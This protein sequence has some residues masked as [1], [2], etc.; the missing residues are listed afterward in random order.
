MYVTDFRNM[1]RVNKYL[2]LD[3]N[4][5]HIATI[6]FPT[7]TS[8]TPSYRVVPFFFIYYFNPNLN[9]LNTILF[10]CILFSSPLFLPF[11]YIFLTFSFLSFFFIVLYNQLCMLSQYAH[12]SLYK[13]KTQIHVHTKKRRHIRLSFQRRARRGC[14]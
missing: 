13:R 10:N 2:F 14:A 5:F 12:G 4:Y 8:I 9:H 6:I 7:F 1:L 3:S 11:C